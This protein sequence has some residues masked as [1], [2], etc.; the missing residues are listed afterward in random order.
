MIISHRYKFIFIKTNKTAGTSVEI[1]LSRACGPDD[2]ITPI[3]RED[4][5]TRASLGYRGPQNYLSSPSE[6][7]LKDVSKLIVRRERKR[8]FYNH[9]AAHA[10]RARIGEAMWND[11]FKFCFERNPWDRV[12]SLYYWKARL[13]P[14]IEISEFVDSGGAAILKQRGYELYT[15]NGAIAVDKVYRFETIKEDLADIRSR[16]SISE[17]LNLPLAKAQFRKD[18]RSYRDIL[19]EEEQRKIAALFGDEI[20]LFGYEF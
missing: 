14:A 12:V 1:A 16:L 18:R 10:I 19:S 7:N 8:A 17:E 2:I 9:M 5:G 15:I 20:R 13:N 11:Y 6:Y 4:E 3:S